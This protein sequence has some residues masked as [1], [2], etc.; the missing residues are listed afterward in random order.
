M[1]AKNSPAVSYSITSVSRSSKIFSFQT[2]SNPP[3]TYDKIHWICYFTATPLI[4]ILM[5]NLHT[6]MNPETFPALPSN[7]CGLAT[8]SA[9]GTVP[10]P[11]AASRA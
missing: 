7:V 2:S 3:Y 9:P 11:C 1:F 5:Y 8:S 10:P 4:F 6:V